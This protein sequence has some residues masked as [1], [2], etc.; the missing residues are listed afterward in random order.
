VLVTGGRGFVGGHV[1]EH[2]LATTDW[3]IVTVDRYR[4]R[5]QARV[6]AVEFDLSDP[7][8]PSVDD[9]VGEIDAVVHLAAVSDVAQFLAR[10]APLLRNNIDLTLNLL[11]WARGRPEL[12]HFVQV[13]TNEI[14][15]PAPA[16]GGAAVEWAPLVPPTP[17]SASKAAQEMAAVAWWRSY[18]VPVA[19]M[20]TMHLFGERQ[21]PNRIVPVAVDRLL[22]GQP[23]P[24]HA[25]AAGR[26]S[27]RCWLYAADFADAVR[28]VLCRPVTRWGPAGRPDRW[29]VAGPELSLDQLVCRIARM[30]NVA[31]LM[32]HVDPEETRPG[33]EPRYALDASAI[34]RAGWWP[35]LGIGMG[36]ERTVTWIRHHRG[37]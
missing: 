28:W 5:P 25:D 7:V 32:V 10:P 4:R 26:T 23:V 6:T 2:L 20:N 35:P 29:H 15:G 16:H 34:D 31:P 27:R 8:P 37:E 11:E 33:H 14:Y 9:E 21:P 13:S 1:I 18:D 3:E 24:V 30:M 22:R 19:L 36:L 17:Y 12:T